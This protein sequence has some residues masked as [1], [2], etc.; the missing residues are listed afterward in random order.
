MRPV[1]QLGEVVDDDV[2]AVLEQRVVAGAAVDADDEA[3]AAGPAGGDAGDGVLDHDR[4]RR[5]DA[6]AVGGVQE[7][8]G[9]RLAGDVLG[10]RRRPRR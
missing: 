4:P 6:E 7:H 1:Q 3:E 9:R 8:V 10:R 2:G 5:V